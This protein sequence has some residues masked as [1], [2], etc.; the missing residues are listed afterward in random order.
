MEA[1]MNELKNKLKALTVLTEDS[2][3]MTIEELL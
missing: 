3:E 1:E 2:T